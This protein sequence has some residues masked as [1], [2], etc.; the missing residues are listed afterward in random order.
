M[1]KQPREFKVIYS[2]TDPSLLEHI[3]T[4]VVKT[5]DHSTNKQDKRKVFSSIWGIPQDFLHRCLKN[6]Y[7]IE[8]KVTVA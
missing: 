4:F 6:S 8:V 5:T 1:A 7:T 3:V 2:L